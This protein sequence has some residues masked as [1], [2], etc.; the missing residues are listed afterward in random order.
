MRGNSASARDYC[1]KNTGIDGDRL[2]GTEPFEHG[3]FRDTEIVSG[4]Q[5]SRSDVTECENG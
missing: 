3:D 1:T 5:G 2:P 4:G